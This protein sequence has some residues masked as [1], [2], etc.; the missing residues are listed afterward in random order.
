MRPIPAKF[1][2]GLHL[3]QKTMPHER[4]WCCT[5]PQRHTHEPSHYHDDCAWVRTPRQRSD[6][7]TQR[8]TRRSTTEN[9]LWHRRQLFTAWSGSQS[10]SSIWYSFPDIACTPAST[11]GS[12]DAH[13]TLAAAAWTHTRGQQGSRASAAHGANTAAT[14]AV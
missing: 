3:S 5:A 4:Q 12:S 11:Q 2:M 7:A 8:R 14:E 10:T 6:A 1:R 13:A 9:S